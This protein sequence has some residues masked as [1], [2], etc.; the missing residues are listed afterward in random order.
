MKTIHTAA[1]LKQCITDQKKADRTIGFVPTMGYLHEGHLSLI[2]RAKAE[3]DYVI[4]SIFVNPLQFGP[5][6]DFD[7]YPRDIERDQMLA[8]ESGTDLLFHPSVE[9]M[10]PKQPT[11]TLKVSERADVLCG[12]SRKGHFDGVATVVAKLFMLTQPDRAYFGLKDA[13]QVSV[14]EAMVSDLNLPV[15]IVPCDTVR[16]KDGLA[17]SSRNVF[18]T[19]EE[20]TEAAGIYAALKE[21][22]EMLLSG[23][24]VNEAQKRFGRSLAQRVSGEVDYAEILS[25]PELLPPNDNSARLIAAAAVKYSKARLID[26]ILIDRSSDGKEKRNNDV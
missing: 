21:A 12:G 14:I 2:R 16:E 1:E 24:N 20:R 22:G 26:N 18:L 3:N 10:Y 19:K 5:N 15:N 4:V 17:K 9:M 23:M 13:Q 8:A 25:Y 11:V 6:E 7:R